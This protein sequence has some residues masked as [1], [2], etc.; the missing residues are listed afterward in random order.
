MQRRYHKRRAFQFLFFIILIGGQFSYSDWPAFRNQDSTGATDNSVIQDD[1]EQLQISWKETIPGKGHSTPLLYNG[2]IYVST[3]IELEND[4]ISWTVVWNWIM[5]VSTFCLI[6]TS[7]WKF[8]NDSNSRT[9]ISFYG[10]CLCLLMILVF[11]GEFLLKSQTDLIRKYISAGM[12][13]SLLCFVVSP[14]RSNYFWKTC[15][16]GIGFLA[17]LILF[18]V[19]LIPFVIEKKPALLCF[20]L[21][22]LLLPVL[23]SYAIRKK[24]KTP[25]KSSGSLY[26]IIWI[27]LFCLAAIPVFHSTYRS[28]SSDFWEIQPVRSLNIPHWYFY[29]LL[30]LLCVCV[31]LWILQQK[32]KHLATLACLWTSPCVLMVLGILGTWT[33]NS[34]LYL[35]YHIVRGKWCSSVGNKTGVIAMGILTVSL[36][37]VSLLKTQKPIQ[38]TKQCAVAIFALTVLCSI[39]ICLSV[40]SAYLATQHVGAIC[41]FD[42]DSGQL[43]WKTHAISISKLRIKNDF[44]SDATPTPIICNEIVVAYF[45]Q[46][47]MSGCDAK[48]GSLLWSK[49]PMRYESMYGA[50]SSLVASQKHALFFLQNDSSDMQS[51]SAFSVTSGALRWK[52]EIVTEASWRSPIIWSEKDREILCVWSGRENLYLYQTSDGKEL[53]HITDIILGSGDPV[54]SPVYC[55]GQLYLAGSDRVVSIATERALNGKKYALKSYTTDDFVETK[56]MESLSSVTDIA[57]EGLGP[58]CST[59]ALRSPYLV[60]I[61]DMGEMHCFDIKSGAQL[62]KETLKATY[63]SPLIAGNYVYTVD[64]QGELFVIKLSEQFLKV[65]QL[66]L[67][68]QVYSSLVASHGKLYVRTDSHLYCLGVKK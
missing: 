29:T 35:Q 1:T 24:R 61:G 22:A 7:W 27:F 50:A 62:W 19:N 5:I 51:V 41:C 33:I 20:P 14:I 36:S 65:Q 9:A 53:L 12:L 25:R 46:H 13:I 64:T 16:A 66:G 30:G 28:Q 10:A 60:M 58:V 11:W 67:N 3:A 45:G 49:S 56:D 23:S 54:A 8:S 31:C 47:G 38:M 2:N 6:V 40:N 15:L 26:C 44:N 34:S 59:P 42:A 32:R 57:L 4:H 43:K 52:K 55:N 39:A 48:T 68:E 17:M 21:L 18:K 37:A 63:S